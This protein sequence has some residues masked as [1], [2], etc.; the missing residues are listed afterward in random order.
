MPSGETLAAPSRIGRAA[1]SL[2]LQLFSPRSVRGR[3]ARAVIA[4]SLLVTSGRRGRGDIGHHYLTIAPE[5]VTERICTAFSPAGACAAGAIIA[6]MTTPLNHPRPTALAIWLILAGAVGW[7]AAF[8]LTV[9]RMKLLADPTASAACDISLLVQC[10]ANLQSWQGS[11]FGFPNPILGLTGWMAPVVVGAALL[12]NARFARWFWLAFGLGV[13]AALAFVIWL[14][15]QSIYVLGTLCPWCMVTWS[16]TIPTFF[17]VI[18]HLLR[19]GAIPVPERVQRV[20][21]SLMAWVPLMSIGAFAVIGLLAQLRL[22][23]IAEF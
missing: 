7:I 18:V 11:V 22:N 20:A 14:I 19:I 23:W 17:A 16:V 3:A 4:R 8:E 2:G 1:N 12:A 13:T 10:G 5:T 6:P 9:E 21:G 15:S